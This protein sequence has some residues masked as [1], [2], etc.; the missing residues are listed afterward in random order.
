MPDTEGLPTLEDV[1]E[2]AATLTGVARETPVLSDD[3]LDEFAGAL[4]FVKAEFLQRGG[5][6]KFR[7]IY[8]K[9]ASLEPNGR[10]RGVVI[11]SSGNAGL[12]TALAARAFETSSIVVMPEHESAV[13][14][15]AIEVAGGHVIAFG[16][17]SDEMLARANEIATEQRRAYVH[18][19][20][21]PEVIAGQGTVGLELD[22][23]INELDAVLVPAGGGGMLSGIGLVL[24]ALRPEIEI[25]GVEPEGAN[26]IQRSLGN[27]RV[28]ELDEISTIAEGLAV[29]TCGRLTFDLIQR[30]AD[31]VLSVTDA[32]ILRAV[33]V[34]W[35]VLHVAVEPS[36]AAALAAL[37]SGDRFRGR[38]VAVIASGANVAPSQ[39]DEAAAAAPA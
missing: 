6:F 3:L 35:N 32:E 16:R 8:N 27:G 37:L 33:G 25:L 7:G 5:S 28:T 14:R 15:A 11:A 17:T 23:Q 34:F 21:Q 36:G 24:R 30:D 4:V 2:A 29:R 22:R 1:R 31:D 18:P 12:A 20:D 38:R 26:S 10:E 9:L 13:K 39:L 19:F